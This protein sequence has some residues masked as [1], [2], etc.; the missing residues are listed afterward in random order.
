MMIF[1]RSDVVRF[2]ETSAAR[3]LGCKYGAYHGRTTAK[4]FGTL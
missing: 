2:N 4:S 3:A 1:G